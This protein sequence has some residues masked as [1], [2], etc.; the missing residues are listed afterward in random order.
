MRYMIICCLLML[1]IVGGQSTLAAAPDKSLNEPSPT[2][3]TK[4]ISHVS[5][6]AV[7]GVEKIRVVF[8]T[9]GPVK[10]NSSISA[11][12]SPRLT[13]NVKGAGRGSVP[14]TLDFD[15]N[16]INKVSVIERE[17]GSS[18]L[19][20]DI[21]TL[22]GD[23]DY[24]VFTLRNDPSANRPYRIVIDI[25][26]P[27][28]PVVYNFTPGLKDKVIAVDAGHGGSDP[29]A[30]GLS[31]VYEKSI[32]LAVAGKVKK[33]LEKAGSQVIMTR[34]TDCDIA[35][36]N[37]SDVAEL[38]GRTAIANNNKA[39]V[40]LSIHT[41]SFTDRTVGGSAVYF[42]QK[43][44]Y[45]LLL[46]Q[47]LDSAL[48]QNS[49]FKDRGVSRGNLYLTKYSLM[50]AALIEMAFISN[51]SEEKLLQ[52]PAVQQQIAQNIVNGLECFFAEAAKR[53]GG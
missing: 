4:V 30:I 2:V 7:T 10:I 52:S 50:P 5:K 42:T 1:C 32:T 43:S 36:R 9:S 8:E 18:T 51:P 25:N 15:G 20:V 13:V 3:M 53:G 29:G 41:N 21:P 14:D 6:D 47:S 28:P 31:G 49:K 24:R 22:L 35:G 46:A 39:D 27:V 17:D 26:K 48:M 12:P 34:E 19:L 38:G 45:D 11:S 33:L 40:F 16:I 44:M 37:A 23:G